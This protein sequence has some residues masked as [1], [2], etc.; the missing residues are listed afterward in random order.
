M[1]INSETPLQNIFIISLSF[2]LVY[3]TLSIL[4]FTHSMVLVNEERIELLKLDIESDRDIS[5][6]INEEVEKSVQDLKNELKK[7][8]GENNK[9][10]IKEIKKNI[11]EIEKEIR[12]IWIVGISK[13]VYNRKLKQQLNL[14]KAGEMFF[15]ATIL[16]SISFFFIYGYI[17]FSKTSFPSDS[18]FTNLGQILV[19]NINL[20]HLFVLFILMIGFLSFLRGLY[21]TFHVVMYN[22]GY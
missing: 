13:N 14:R 20:F 12:L 3:A 17:I 9:N 5:N 19:N 16:S 1:Y 6:K 21:K 11:K 4:S 7:L 15:M 8:E 2:I 22:V 10:S 18:I